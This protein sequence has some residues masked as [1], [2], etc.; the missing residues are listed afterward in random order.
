MASAFK[1]SL[2]EIRES[3]KMIKILKNNTTASKKHEMMSAYEEGLR[4]DL[5][6]KAERLINLIEDK[7]LAVTSIQGHIFYLKM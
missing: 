1:G 5:I 4:K 3:L 7:V 6:Q 2:I